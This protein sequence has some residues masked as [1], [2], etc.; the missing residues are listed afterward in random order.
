M[1]IEI[2]HN[3]RSEQQWL[4][5]I[6]RQ[7][8]FAAAGALNDT[9][10]EVRRAEIAAMSVFDR[11]TPYTLRSVSVEKASKTRLEGK[12]EVSHYRGQ[13]GG[14]PPGKVLEAEVWAGARHWKRSEILWQKLGLLARGWYAVPGPAAQLDGY[15]N[16]ARGQILHLLSWFRAYPAGQFNPN[17]KKAYK[18][19]TNISDEGRA[20]LKRGTPSRIGREYFAVKVGEEHGRLRP[21]IYAVETP[22]RRFVGPSRRL[23]AVLYFVN[24]AQYRERYPFHQVAEREFTARFPTHFDKRFDWAMANAR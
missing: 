6:A 10:F 24:R 1:R 20:K 19:R 4:R 11:P 7:A 15:G 22:G 21:G 14:V 2:G 9:L 13:A 18:G 23:R 12:V 8:D 16:M 5:T 17:R 3:F